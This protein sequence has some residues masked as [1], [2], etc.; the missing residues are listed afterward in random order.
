MARAQALTHRNE[1]PEYAAAVAEIAKL[2][3]ALVPVRGR[4]NEITLLLHSSVT[5]SVRNEGHVEAA[6]H[7]VDTG[8]VRRSHDSES[9]AEDHLRLREQAEALETTIQRKQEALYRLEQKLSA[10]A[11][12]SSQADLAEIRTRYLAKLR[13]L[14]AIAIEE[15]S[16]L[17]A[18]NAKGYYPTPPLPVAWPLIGTLS[19]PQSAI[20]AHVRDLT[21][22]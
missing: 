14:D 12:D 1:Q 20:S 7:F 22:G 19:D 9:L 13:E 6:L 8:T 15:Q 3:A 11:L 4:I 10:T 17:N 2:Q 18:L 5:E 16:L 21:R